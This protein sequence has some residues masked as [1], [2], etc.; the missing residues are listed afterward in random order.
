MD[1]LKKPTS[2]RFCASRVH[3]L[4][5]EI[6]SSHGRSQQHRCGPTV[7]LLGGSFNPAHD[8]HLHVSLWALKLLSLNGV[9]WLVTPGNPLKPQG[10]QVSVETRLEMAA[11]TVHH[12]RIVVTNIETR[13]RTTYTVDT[14]R[15]LNAHNTGMRFIWLMGSDCLAEMHLWKDWKQIF[16]AIPICVFARPDRL[17]Q[18][19]NSVAARVFA[20]SRLPEREANL[21][22]R[23]EPPA[24]VFASIPLHAASS[25]KHRIA[26]SWSC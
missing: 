13:Y 5:R 16:S 21:L 9:W 23:L 22:Q 14:L 4:V 12:P 11:A 1:I 3:S 20:D 2:A 6:T 19:R 8:G 7:G 10:S 24:W 25:T 17:S 15:K 18:A 26:Q